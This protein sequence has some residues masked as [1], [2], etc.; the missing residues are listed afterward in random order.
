MLPFRP[1]KT[2]QVSGVIGA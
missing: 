1:K 2:H